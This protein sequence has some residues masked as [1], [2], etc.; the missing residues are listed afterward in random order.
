MKYVLIYIRVSYSF[1]FNYTYIRKN[2][3]KISI[4]LR[5]LVFI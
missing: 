2:E 5:K 3:K 1:T 4:I